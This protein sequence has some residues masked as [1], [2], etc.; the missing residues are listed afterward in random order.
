MRLP[1]LRVGMQVAE[2][3]VESHLVELGF[4]T[5]DLRFALP[6]GRCAV[7]VSTVDQNQLKIRTSFGMR[8][9][10]VPD[11]SHQPPCK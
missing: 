5:L 9:L 7:S 3:L 6:R 4:K 2:N 11:S 10:T 1:I 8:R